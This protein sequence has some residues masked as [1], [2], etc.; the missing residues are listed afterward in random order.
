MNP[1]RKSRSNTDNSRGPCAQ[2][3][4]G[5]NR[6]RLS[7]KN[8]PVMAWEPP[9]IRSRHNSRRK[10]K[11][12]R[13]K[14]CQR[15]RLNG[16]RRRKPHVVLRHYD[17]RGIVGVLLRAA[18]PFRVRKVVVFLPL[19]PSVLKPDFHLA[20]WEHQRLRDLN[21]PLP[22]QVPVKMELFLQFQQ[23]LS[24]V[25]CPY[26]LRNS[27]LTWWMHKELLHTRTDV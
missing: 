26:S 4:L 8:A 3:T 23:L 27:I 1:S 19:H 6:W 22:G 5:C 25:R 7:L 12:L 13:R 20:L 15:W 14:S 9:S 11:I 16:S 18:F 24:S 17:V 21:P 10:K 2:R